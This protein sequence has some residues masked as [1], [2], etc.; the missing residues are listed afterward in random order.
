MPATRR[1]NPDELFACV[2]LV[3]LSGGGEAFILF[4]DIVDDTTV[5]VQQED[6]SIASDEVHGDRPFERSS[7]ELDS[8]CP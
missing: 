2:E 5:F 4:T 3:S 7:R 1:E 6:G 8:L